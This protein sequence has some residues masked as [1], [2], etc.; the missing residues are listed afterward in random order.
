M[1]FTFENED[2][3]GEPEPPTSENES[4]SG[5]A[6]PKGALSQTIT[7]LLF[8]LGIAIPRTGQVLRD[9]YNQS[10]SEEELDGE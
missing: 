9:L 3:G 10:S 8:S 6:T 4:E 2:S 1:D 7:S 5:S